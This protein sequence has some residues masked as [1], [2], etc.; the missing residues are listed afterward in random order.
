MAAG[1]ILLAVC[2]LAWGILHSL[3]ADDRIAARVQRLTRTSPQGYR[4]GYNLIALVTILPVVAL[5]LRLMTEPFIVWSSWLLPLRMVLA[6]CA[7]YLLIAPCRQYDMAV[8]IGLRREKSAN[9]GGLRTGGI[10]A[11]VR[12]PWYSAA[13]IL[14]WL[15]DIDPAGAIT[16]VVLSLYLIVGAFCEERRLLRSLGEE[17]AAYRRK[18]PM[19]IPKLGRIAL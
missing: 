18:V 5:Y 17:Y 10:L 2:W 15:R 4:L 3:L 8:F 13:L 6:G 7:L 16:A 1:L 14:L 11:R 19:F 12:H 9:G